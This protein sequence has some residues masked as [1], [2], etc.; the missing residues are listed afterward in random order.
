MRE[1][2]ELMGGHPQRGFRSRKCTA[3]INMLRKIWISKRDHMDRW[4]D[5]KTA[6]PKRM[7]CSNVERA[8]VN[9]ILM[10]HHKLFILHH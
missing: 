1:E 2:I 8:F 7:K 3:Q 6:I 5:G 9:Q 10:V 4:H